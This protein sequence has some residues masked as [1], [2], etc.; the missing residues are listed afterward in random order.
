MSGLSKRHI[1]SSHPWN[2]WMCVGGGSCG[3]AERPSRL[4]DCGTPRCVGSSLPIYDA[5]FFFFF[6]FSHTREAPLPPSLLGCFTEALRLFLMRGKKHDCYEKPPNFLGLSF[7]NWP[8]L[9][10]LKG[11][12][13]FQFKAM[14]ILISSIKKPSYPCHAL[15]W[16]TDS[17]EIS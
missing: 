14:W 3:E 2:S 16:M 1:A 4:P 17:G 15:I 9:L 5:F 12:F 11:S 8:F 6:C 7:L 10:H 13:R